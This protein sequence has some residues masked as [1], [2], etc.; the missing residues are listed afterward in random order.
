[1][2]VP[3]KSMNYRAPTNQPAQ[4]A[5]WQGLGGGAKGTFGGTLGEAKPIKYRFVPLKGP[6]PFFKLG[7]QHESGRSSPLY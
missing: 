3:L 4:A 7:F 6:A 5:Q 2:R 1:M